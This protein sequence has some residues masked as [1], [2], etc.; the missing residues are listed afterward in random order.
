MIFKNAMILSG[1]ET[2][3][4]DIE[5]RGQIISKI[6]ENLSGEGYDLK[7]AFVT[8]GAIDPHAHFRQPGFEAKE[9]IKTGSLSAAKGGVFTA[10]AMPNLNPVPDCAENLQK[11]IDIIKRDACITVLPF[12]AVT[13]GQQGRQLSDIASI[14]DKVVAFS[15]DGKCVNDTGLLLEAMQEVKKTGKIICSHAEAAGYGDSEQAEYIAVER[16]LNLVKKSGV[17]YHFCHMSTAES[18]DLIKGAKADGMDVSCEVTPHH[19]SY[20]AVEKTD[21][22]FKMNPPLRQKKDVEAARAALLDGTADMIATDH[23][24]HTEYEKSQAWNIAPYGIIGF[25]TLYPVVITSLY[26]TGYISLASLV[27]FTRIGAKNRFGIDAGEIKEGEAATFCA[28]DID[29]KRTYKKSEI[30]SM[31]KNSPYIGMDLYG[32]N[33]VSVINGKI[34]YIDT[35]ALC[36]TKF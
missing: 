1:S 3:I 6:G 17:K 9:T 19:L 34:K 11:E 29:N 24:P 5:V 15:D 30:L 35:E 13:K 2:K 31:G 28:L 22:N 14:A 27:R 36:Q 20:C 26:K 32:F 21:A 7:G 18:F 25:E 4:V 10:F 33:L 16:E 12:G 23:A 8:G